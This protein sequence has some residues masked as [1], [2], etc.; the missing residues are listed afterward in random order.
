MPRISRFV[1]VA[2]A[3]LS[4]SVISLRFLF[5]RSVSVLLSAGAYFDGGPLLGM[6]SEGAINYPAMCRMIAFCLVL[7][8]WFPV[9]GTSWASGPWSAFSCLSVALILSPLFRCQRITVC[10]A[11]SRL[12]SFAAVASRLEQRKM[13]LA[14]SVAIAS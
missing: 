5:L 10:C 8:S 9:L 2:G 14:M 12:L 4:R 3:Y 11:Q 13:A 7:T 6:K 1:L